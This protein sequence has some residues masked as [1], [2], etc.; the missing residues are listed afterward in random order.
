LKR[1]EEIDGL[2]VES[3]GGAFYMFVRLTDPQWANDDKQF[4]L[5]LLEEEHVLLVHGSGFSPELGRGHVRLVYLPS[6]EV[7]D[8]AF[9][10]IERFLE[11]HR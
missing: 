9:D 7:L 5:R 4:V 2:E 10:R 11:R 6:V 3:P 1:I 8:E